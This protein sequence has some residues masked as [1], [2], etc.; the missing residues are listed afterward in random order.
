MSGSQPAVDHDQEDL[1]EGRRH[2]TRFRH[3]LARCLSC[4]RWVQK[5]GE[6]EILRSKIGPRLRA[7]SLYL[8][9][10]IGIS[11]RKVPRAIADLF[12]VRFTPA[13]LIGFENA[14]SQSQ[15]EH[16][17]SIGIESFRFTR[18]GPTA[19]AA[20]AALFF[21][22]QSFMPAGAS[23][24]ASAPRQTRM[25]APRPGLLAASSARCPPAIAVSPA[26]YCRKTSK[27]LRSS[28]TIQNGHPGPQ[29][30]YPPTPSST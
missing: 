28:T 3:P 26:C 1:I 22:G 6:G 14:G 25:S 19:Q 24:D 29:R 8:R 18:R 17:S 7:M 20:G 23:V 9:H 5:P 21:V 12:S 16:Q 2:V 11:L 15:L 27:F 4:R 30:P 13:A 10:D